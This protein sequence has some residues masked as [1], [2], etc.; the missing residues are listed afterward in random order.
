[1]MSD[2]DDDE[3]SFDQEEDL[4]RTGSLEE[5]DLD[6]GADGSGSGT[7]RRGGPPASVS[8][9][10]M[11]SSASMSITGSVK[12]PMSIRRKSIMDVSMP[13]GN[14]QSLV[15]SSHHRAL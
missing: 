15:A 1:M 9:S 13:A 12:G 2:D 8:S 7:W 11:R 10:M 5:Q 6:A 14:K 4:G 3:D